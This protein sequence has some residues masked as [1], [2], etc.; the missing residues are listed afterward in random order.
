MAQTAA[1]QPEPQTVRP[2]RPTPPGAT[3]PM[4]GGQNA[5]PAAI[6]LTF[7]AAAAVGLAAAAIA[8]VFTAQRVIDAPT[9]R[10]VVATAHLFTLAFLTTAMLGAAHQ[11]GPVISTAPLRSTA[12]GR[13]CSLAFPPAAWLLALGFAVDLPWLVSTAGSI[14]FTLVCLV[15][16]NL[17]G[18]LLQ[19]GKGLAIAGLRIAVAM[20][21]VTAAFGI[22][23]AFDR[24]A[25]WFGLLPRR[26][27]AHAHLG[28]VAWLG[29]GYVSVAE[30]LWPLF[31][32]AHRPN[33]TSGR[34]IV[35]LLPAGASVLAVALLIPNRAATY[36]G[37][38]LIGAGLLLHAASF[39]GVMKARRRE[40][41]LLHAF[42]GAS[43]ASMAIALALAG[44]LAAGSFDSATTTRLVAAEV[45]ALLGW[46][47]LAIIGHSHKIVPFVEWSSLR[48][49][50][51]ARASGRPLL[52][53]HLYRKDVAIATFAAAA[54]GYG[55]AIA[56]VLLASAVLLRAGACAL[57]AAALS[58]LVNLAAGPAR[59]RRQQRALEPVPG[60]AAPLRP[61]A[62]PN[63]PEENA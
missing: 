59:V 25:G 18:P 4:G 7:F 43:I 50:G 2:T 32:L 23:Y 45:L 10:Q 41:E 58:A 36:L 19:R 44:L 28:L 29:T 26:V 17:S 16:W 27:L 56:G 20:L 8:L 49:K 55:A 47:G 62:E 40:P 31:L 34:W 6:P 51:I 15:A 22:T 12:V 21:F 42:I 60:P 37:A 3:G 33:R 57:V 35:A 5:P 63:D 61:A 54:G 39:A 11:F 53:S 46:I 24:Q 9:S 48:A 52:F 14:A 30:K 38:G 1:A 13:A